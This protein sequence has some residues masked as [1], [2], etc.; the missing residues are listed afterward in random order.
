[1][2]IMMGS[3]FYQPCDERHPEYSR[4]KVICDDEGIDNTLTE[5][6][7]RVG[8]PVGRDGVAIDLQTVTSNTFITSTTQQTLDSIYF[9]PGN[10]IR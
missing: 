4:T 1:M 2:M 7:W 9:G 5:Y 3:S 10:N 6:R 8:Q